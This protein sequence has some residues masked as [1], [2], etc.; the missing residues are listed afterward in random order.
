MWGWGPGRIA[1]RREF[2]WP[3]TDLRGLRPSHAIGPPEVRSLQNL[4]VVY[5]VETNF[6]LRLATYEPVRSQ[7]AAKPATTS[8]P[9]TT[10]RH[11]TRSTRDL[12]EQVLRPHVR[13]GLVRARSPR[14]PPNPQMPSTDILCSEHPAGCA[15]S[16][17]SR[18]PSA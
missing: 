2:S 16:W 11:A 12:G 5:G 8:R 10:T 18:L 1:S 13:P 9:R 7:S 6:G 4:R 3:A 14:A 15:L 17:P